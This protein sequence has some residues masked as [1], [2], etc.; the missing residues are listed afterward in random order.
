MVHR[1]EREPARPCDRLGRREPD[2]QRA[3]EAGALRDGDLLDVV[4]GRPC[5]RQRLADDGCD[6]LEV[7]PRRDF[8][9]DAAEPGVQLGL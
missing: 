3:N 1:D 8:G 2:E 4:E 6:E 5:V 9:N 7:P